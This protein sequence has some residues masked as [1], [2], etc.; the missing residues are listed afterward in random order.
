MT[1][2]AF[3]END[4]GIE[5]AIENFYNLLCQRRNTSLR[6]YEDKFNND[7][8]QA[9]VTF[10][11]NETFRIKIHFDHSQDMWVCNAHD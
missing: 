11:S 10:S 5:G 4:L 8:Y 6:K 3:Y 9:T 2:I 1:Y 7:Q